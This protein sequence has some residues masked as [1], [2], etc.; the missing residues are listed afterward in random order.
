MLAGRQMAVTKPGVGRYSGCPEGA[1]SIDD[2]ATAT[3]F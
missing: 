3:G 2:G 1:V